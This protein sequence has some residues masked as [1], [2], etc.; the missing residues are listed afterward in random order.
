VD[1]DD[2]IKEEE[3]RNKGKKIMFYVEKHRKGRNMFMTK[4]RVKK[5]RDASRRK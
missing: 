5:T 1:D 4:T 2:T 3:I